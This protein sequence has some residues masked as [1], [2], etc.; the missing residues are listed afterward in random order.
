MLNLLNGTIARTDI[1]QKDTSDLLENPVNFKINLK[2]AQ[3]FTM[4]GVVVPMLDAGSLMLDTRYPML[5]PIAIGRI[6]DVEKYYPGF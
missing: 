2:T 6:L 1:S 3:C 4:D 5:V